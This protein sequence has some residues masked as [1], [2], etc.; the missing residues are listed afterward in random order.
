M[1]QLA[2]NLYL[3]QE[4]DRKKL[5]FWL[6]LFR[7]EVDA[8]DSTRQGWKFMSCSHSQELGQSTSWLL[9]GCTIVNNQ[10]EARTA[11]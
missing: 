4:K 11:S 3:E 6:G 7:A 5:P 1:F 9:I 8:G 2:N 10:P